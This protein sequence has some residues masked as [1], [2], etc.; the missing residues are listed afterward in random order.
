[1]AGGDFETPAERLESVWLPD[2]YAVIDA[3]LLPGMEK[4][5]EP[6]TSPQPA[7]QDLFLID[8]QNPFLVELTLQGACCARCR[9]TAGTTRKA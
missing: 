4:D 8:G 6:R 9:S 7:D 5:K 3:K 1:M 2:Y